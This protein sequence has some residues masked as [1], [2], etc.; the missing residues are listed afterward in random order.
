MTAAPSPMCDAVRASQ[1]R[2][3]G[4]FRTTRLR[5]EGLGTIGR[6]TDPDVLRCTDGSAGY[7][8]DRFQPC[9]LSKATATTTV[10]LP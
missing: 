7:L 10:V 3:N 8:K 4:P 6:I 5:P 1:N 2:P 9:P